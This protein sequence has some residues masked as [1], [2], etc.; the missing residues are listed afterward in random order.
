[1]PIEIGSKRNLNDLNME[2]DVKLI[3]RNNSEVGLEITDYFEKLWG[4][5]D[6]N[7]YTEG[8]ESKPKIS[9]YKYLK[10]RVQ[11]ASGFCAWWLSSSH[12]GK[13]K[14]APP[15]FEPGSQGIS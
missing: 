15:G 4:N 9:S 12:Q 2:A 8:Y 3:T 14:I 11:E 7:N 5:E 13:K 1:M 10:Y 6:G